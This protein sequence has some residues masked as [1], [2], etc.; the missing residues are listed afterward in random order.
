M[1]RIKVERP[2]LHAKLREAGMSENVD[3]VKM[4]LGKTLEKRQSYV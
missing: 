2:E 3:D 1:E 4:D